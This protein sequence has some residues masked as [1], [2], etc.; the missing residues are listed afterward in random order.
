MPLSTVFVDTYINRKFIFL[1]KGIMTT[2]T[3]D[4]LD[5]N[6]LSL[7]KDL[8]LLKVIR[9]HNDGEN[10]QASAIERIKNLKGLM[11]KQSPE[12]IDKQLADLR[13]EWD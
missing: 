12:E 9:L 13:N 1:N 2:V 11:T 7:L 4:I 3:L 5:D 8:E 6:A 10:K